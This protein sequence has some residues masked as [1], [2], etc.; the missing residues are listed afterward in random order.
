MYPFQGNLLET[1][2]LTPCVFSQHNYGPGVGSSGW[3]WSMDRNKLSNLNLRM[4]VHNV[5]TFRGLQVNPD[6]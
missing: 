5:T 2:S 3:I 6:Q 4:A 1:V